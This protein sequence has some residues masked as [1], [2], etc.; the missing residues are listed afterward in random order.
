MPH[1]KGAQQE[2]ALVIILHNAVLN[3]QCRQTDVRL[4]KQCLPLILG[5]FDFQMT[6]AQQ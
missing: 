5:L 2:R 4:G 6:S 3:N 1:L